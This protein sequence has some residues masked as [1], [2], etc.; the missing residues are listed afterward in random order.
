MFADAGLSGVKGIVL[1]AVGTLIEPRPSVAE[2]YAQ[3][4]WRQGVT[5]DLPLVRS[6]FREQFRTDEIDELH[7]PLATSEEVEHRRWRRIVSGCLPEVPDPDRAFEELWVHFGEPSSW[8]VFPDV[9]RALAR[10]V[11]TS[12]RMC[13]ASNFDSRLRRV[14][15]GLPALAGWGGS[16][17][18]SSEVGYRKPHRRF[19]EAACS[20]L[21]LSPD[22]VLCVGD[23]LENDVRGPV[24]AGL[25]AALVERESSGRG[26]VPTY[27][28]LGA[29]ADDLVAAGGRE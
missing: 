22:R 16:I 14:A 26:D 11:E 25:R 1:D 12:F 18:V 28:G 17:V 4:A 27:S 9:A 20:H 8:I 19:Y 3:A 10:L 7:G 13:V 23:D 29:L 15:A 6:R 21:D 2:A 5:L 24:R